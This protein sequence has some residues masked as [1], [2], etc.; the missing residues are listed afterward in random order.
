MWEKKSYIEM[1][2]KTV[3]FW[4]CLLMILAFVISLP[5]LRSVGRKCKMRIGSFADDDFS[6]CK[7]R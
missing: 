7:K 1:S 5:Y 2:S 3:L 6:S 4:G